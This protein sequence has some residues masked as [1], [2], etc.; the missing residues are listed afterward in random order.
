MSF[1]GY[2]LTV[3]RKENG[4]GKTSHIGLSALS[5][6]GAKH[7]ST[8]YVR[9]FNLDKGAGC[10]AVLYECYTGR[11]VLRASRAFPEEYQWHIV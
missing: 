7:E 9:R 6:I 8:R 3:F 4:E 10:D 1:Q 2:Q 11:K 5:L